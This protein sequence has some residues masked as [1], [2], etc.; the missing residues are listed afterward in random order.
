[1]TDV[2]VGSHETLAFVGPFAEQEPVVVA[3]TVRGNDN[4]LR[5]ALNA[6]DADALLHVQQ[7]LLADRPSPG[8]VGRIWL[9]T[10]L[11]GLR[12]WY[13][14]G[15]GWVVIDTAWFEVQTI[16]DDITLTITRAQTIVLV[17]TSSNDVDITLPSSLMLLG[18]TLIIK[19]LYAANRVTVT[20]ASG[21][22]DGQT[23]LSW[24]TRYRG[25]TVTSDATNIHVVSEFTNGAAITL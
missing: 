21:T 5:L 14:D 10:D 19:K 12:W 20:P 11:T 13:D 17:D 7:S 1:M 15:G 24:T 16:D 22:I 18:R 8:E 2:L 25:F 9:T 3:N 23:S 6:H 4:I